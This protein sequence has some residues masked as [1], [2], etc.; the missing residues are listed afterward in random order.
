MLIGW[1][2]LKVKKSYV[3]MEESYA[4]I[5]WISFEE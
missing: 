3:A 2:L 1:L 4:A 5:L